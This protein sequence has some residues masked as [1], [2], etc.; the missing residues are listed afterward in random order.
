MFARYQWSKM[1]RTQS[2]LKSLRIGLDIYVYFTYLAVHTL[3]LQI[4]TDCGRWRTGSFES[5]TKAHRAEGECSYQAGNSSDRS[6]NSRGGRCSRAWER[7]AAALR[8]FCVSS[9]HEAML[10]FKTIG[11]KTVLSSASWLTFF[12][13][14]KT[15]K[16]AFFGDGNPRCPRTEAKKRHLVL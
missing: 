7:S 3:I 9:D 4:T 5:T 2:P 15:T 13:G 11:Q 6:A 16:P 1:W 12:R 14:V 10:S 8:A